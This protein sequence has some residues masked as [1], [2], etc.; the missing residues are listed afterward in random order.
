MKFIINI[1]LYF[2]VCCY[3]SVVNAAPTA[4]LDKI[5]FCEESI[6]LAVENQL[7]RHDLNLD[8]MDVNDI[9]MKSLVNFYMH[10]KGFYLTTLSLVN[11]RL[12]KES[13][14]ELNVLLTQGGVISADLSHNDFKEDSGIPLAKVINSA[15]YLREIK[16]DS[17]QLGSN[18]IGQLL[19]NLGS[20]NVLRVLS[21]AYMDIDVKA[22]WWLADFLEKNTTLKEL[23]LAHNNLGGV[24]STRR[25]LE[26]LKVNK[27]LTTLDLSYNQMTG[28][29]AKLIA[30]ELRYHDKLNQLNLKGNFIDDDARLELRKLNV[31]V[32]F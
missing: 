26:G 11:N 28:R 29:S 3:L 9:C 10:Q 12:T 32:L 2:S 21:L 25:I 14:P 19:A 27:N 18:G 13:L 16:L 24:E 7:K 22:A 20:N 17:N 31:L 23:N 4:S 6:D 30:K 8:F 5:P 15:H 1:F